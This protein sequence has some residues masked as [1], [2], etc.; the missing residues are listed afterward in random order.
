MSIRLIPCPERLQ[1]SHKLSHPEIL[2]FE[3]PEDFN[4][5]KVLVNRGANLWPDAPVEVKELADILTQGRI[6]QDY[7]SQDYKRAKALT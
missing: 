5:F 2:V 6:L 1:Q 3:T 4:S 7:L